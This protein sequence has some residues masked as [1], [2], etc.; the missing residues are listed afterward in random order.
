MEGYEMSN[1]ISVRFSDEELETLLD[2]SKTQNKGISTL[3]KEYVFDRLE[4]EYDLKI[5]NEYEKQ[6]RDG[7]LKLYNH[8]EA[9]KLLG[10]AD[11]V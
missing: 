1:V 8:D 7:T 3:I 10:L 5:V 6:K 4:D 9:M 2:V 11:E